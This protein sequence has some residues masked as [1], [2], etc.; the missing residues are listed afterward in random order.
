[1][2]ICPLKLEEY[3]RTTNLP[4]NL[5]IAH[6]N[7]IAGNDQFGRVRLLIIIGRTAPGPQAVESLAAALTGA[8]PISVVNPRATGFIWYPRSNGGIGLRDGFGILTEGD[9]H[10]DPMA[11]AVRWQIHEAQ[12]I[13]ARGRAREVNRTALEPLDIDQLF[14]T[15]L[16]LPVDQ[17]ARW[18]APSVLVATAAA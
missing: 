10:P 3:L 9:Q 17:V 4:A 1:M 13:Q 6:F 14:D 18:Q 11:E 2:V 15:C 5:E 12:L 7:D 16:P 8:Q